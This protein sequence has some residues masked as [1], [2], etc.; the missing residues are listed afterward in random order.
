MFIV[1]DELRVTKVTL[2]GRLVVP[3][4]TWSVTCLR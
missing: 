3:A 1:P 2:T 4:G